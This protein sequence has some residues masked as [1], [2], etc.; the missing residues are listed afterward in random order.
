M[1]RN[2]LE[3]YVKCL[4]IKFNYFVVQT[5]VTQWSFVQIPYILT[6]VYNSKNE[7]LSLNPD[8]NRM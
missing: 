6:R 2:L 5:A 3:N 8:Y 1:I 7:S 4:L